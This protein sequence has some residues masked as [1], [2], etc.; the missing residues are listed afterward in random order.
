[1]TAFTEGN[2]T[3]LLI[4]AAVRQT[5]VHACRETSHVRRP[6]WRALWAVGIAA[7]MLMT[8]GS[9][10]DAHSRATQVTWAADVEPIISARCVRCHHTNG[11]APMPLASYQE[12]REW[13]SAIRTEVLSARMPP[14][15]AAPGY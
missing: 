4:A 13:A 2:S 15:P 14:W 8:G 3:R 10:P 1:M 6:A 7:T 11:F 5:F 12:A 9:A